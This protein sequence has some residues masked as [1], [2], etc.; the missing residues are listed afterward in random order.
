MRS[1]YIKA[2]TLQLRMKKANTMVVY[3]TEKAVS[4]VTVTFSLSPDQL[5]TCKLLFT[6]SYNAGARDDV[7]E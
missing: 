5:F 2:G 7:M 6:T 3:K 4:R 1:C